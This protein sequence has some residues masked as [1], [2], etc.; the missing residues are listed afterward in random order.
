M[1]ITKF[2]EKDMNAAISMAR[3]TWHGYYDEFRAEYIRCIAD[4]IVRHNY[5]DEDLAFKITCNGEASSSAHGKARWQTCPY[6]SASNAR[7]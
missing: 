7:R 2:S 3:Q 4:C 1:E 6:G 5:T